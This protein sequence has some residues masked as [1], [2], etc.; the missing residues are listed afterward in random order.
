MQNQPQFRK[1]G[2]FRVAKAT[3]IIMTKKGK[4]IVF[5]VLALIVLFPVFLYAAMEYSSNAADRTDDCLDDF[6]KAVEKQDYQAAQELFQEQSIEE[7]EQKQALSDAFEYIEGDC[8]SSKKVDFYSLYSMSRYD[9]E[10]QFATYEVKTEE[11]RYYISI[12][13]YVS[14]KKVKGITSLYLIRADE[15]DALYPDHPY[16]GDYMR[17]PGVH[18]G[19]LPS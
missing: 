3:V 16:K 18:V 11:D 17:T 19:V 10:E 1:K 15:W 12:G 13:V 7:Q 5:G 8:K 14:R 4:L 2:S 6:L 9:G